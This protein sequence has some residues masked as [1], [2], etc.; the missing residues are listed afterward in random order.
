MISKFSSIISQLGFASSDHDPVLF[1][2]KTRHG[3]TILLL[4]V[5]DMIITGD[6]MDGI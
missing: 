2:R 1:T 6:D 4:Y 5:D 3:T